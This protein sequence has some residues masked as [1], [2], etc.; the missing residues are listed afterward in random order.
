MQ[1][2]RD[3]TI[4]EYTYLNALKEILTNGETRED[5]TG[6]G[7]KSLFGMQQIYNLKEGFPLLTTK[8]MLLTSVISELLWFIEGSSDERRL[9]EIRYGKDRSEL[10]DKTTIWTDNLKAPYWS[11]KG[12]KSD[13]GKIYG[14]QWRN[15]NGIDQISQLIDGLK[16]NPT[17][18]RHILS[19]WN[20]SDID[21]MALPPCHVL[22]QYYVNSN[23]ELSCQLYQRSADF[24]LGVPYNIASYS[25]FTQMIANVCGLSVGNFIHTIGDAHIY[26]DHIELVEEQLKR[27]PF[28]APYLEIRK[29]DSIDEY[30]MSDFNIIDY[31]FHA[32]LGGK[33]A[34]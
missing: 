22:T 7:T 31:N 4:N 9:A 10:T 18:R 30:T 19:A 6:T 15:W 3:R 16:H 29:V 2:T 28:S 17:S 1:N 13:L 5:R 21:D 24:F 8:K 26:S 11:K 27:E 14:Y 20:V 34:V 23:N 12:H 25:A 33:M 32:R